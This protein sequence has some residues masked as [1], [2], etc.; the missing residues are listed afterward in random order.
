MKKYVVEYRLPYTHVVQI[1]IEAESPEEAEA[2]FQ[3]E[4][5][6]G[7]VWDDR[8]DMPHL[9]DEFEE[10]NAA[11]ETEVTEVEAWPAVDTSVVALKKKEAAFQ[12]AR[13]LVAAYQNGERN[14]GSV[15]WSEV[16]QAYEAARAAVEEVAHG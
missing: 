16:D 12:A 13:L 5:D 4:F 7:T 1:G 11:L 6:N 15:D 14:G 2:R 9:Y 3:Y 10:Q 8:S